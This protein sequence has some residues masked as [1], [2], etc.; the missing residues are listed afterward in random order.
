[1]TEHHFPQYKGYR[2]VLPDTFELYF[3]DRAAMRINGYLLFYATTADIFN[4]SNISREVKVNE[5]E[6]KRRLQ[7]MF[8]DHLAL[9]ATNTP[10]QTI[11]FGLYFLCIKL[12][13]DDR[14]KKN[15]LFEK[16]LT[17]SHFCTGYE[18]EG[19]YD[20][21][22]GFHISSFDK[23]KELIYDNYIDETMEKVHLL[24]V[25]RLLRQE[26]VNHWDLPASFFGEYSFND[27]YYEKLREVQ[28][29]LDD[30]DLNIV[31]AINKKKPLEELFNVNFF[32]DVPPD[33]ARGTLNK[34][35]EKK[36]IVS[37]LFLNWMKLNYNPYLFL[38]RFKPAT[39]TS[40]KME[41]A[42]ELAK[43]HNL[44][45]VM[46]HNDSYFDLSIMVYDKL[47]D[48]GKVR[49]KLRAIKE[50]EEIKEATCTRQTRVWTHR[51]DDKNFGASLM[52]F[53]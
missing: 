33:I 35:Y 4:V 49:D 16:F 11:G 34:M 9:L 27:K 12:G 51:L 14:E 30:V 5:E 37:V 1:M 10:V 41:I 45:M 18:T 8:N 7:R 23:L 43:N 26:G 52:T 15:E 22:L 44:M 13:A 2:Y 50:V 42:D 19:D 31:K 53:D 36:G 47:L 24:P 48:V 32:K 20:F 40:K 6:V 17:D 46:Q 28:N 38:V 21:Y 39:L 25:Q 29:K 3:K